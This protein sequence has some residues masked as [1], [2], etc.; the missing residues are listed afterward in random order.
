M[1]ALSHQVQSR[2]ASGGDETRPEHLAVVW[3]GGSRGSENWRSVLRQ[4][5]LLGFSLLIH[6]LQQLNAI[7]K[8]T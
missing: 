4:T 8:K 1:N 6:Q 5:G 3:A 2:N 7:F